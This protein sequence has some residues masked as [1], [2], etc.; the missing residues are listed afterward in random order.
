MLP[1]IS[2]RWVVRPSGKIFRKLAIWPSKIVWTLSKSTKIKI[3]IFL[4]KTASKQEPPGGL[5]ARLPVGWYETAIRLEL[6][7][8][9]IMFGRY[10]VIQIL[11]INPISFYPE[12]QLLGKMLCL[13]RLFGI[14]I[15]REIWHTYETLSTLCLI[16]DCH[17]WVCP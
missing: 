10:I 11:Y 4:S 7:S 6:K 3:R 17:F 12:I 14:G 15:E 13:V 9:R 5:L 16:Q 1:S 8:N 2:R